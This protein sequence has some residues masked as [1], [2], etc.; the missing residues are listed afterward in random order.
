MVPITN[1]IRCEGKRRS[2]WHH[3]KYMTSWS[4]ERTPSDEQVVSELDY[5]DVEGSD[6]LKEEVQ[7]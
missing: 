7:A 6:D 4:H 3:N 2:V 5:A 1:C